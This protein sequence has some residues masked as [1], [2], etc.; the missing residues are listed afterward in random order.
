MRRCF[1]P[2]RAIRHRPRA[3]QRLPIPPVAGPVPRP[4]APGIPGQTRPRAVTVRSARRA[5]GIVVHA[6]WRIC[7]HQ[8]RLPSTRGG[9]QPVA[10][11]LQKTKRISGRSRIGRTRSQGQVAVGTRLPSN[12]LGRARETSL[13]VIGVY[14]CHPRAT[15]TSHGGVTIRSVTKLP[16]TFGEN[17]PRVWAPTAIRSGLSADNRAIVS[18]LSPLMISISRGVIA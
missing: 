7:H 5:P 9:V 15:R 3:S 10:R 1:A 16:K 18:V 13:F 12:L 6:E 17:P 2:A 8:V 14:R 4:P 11:N